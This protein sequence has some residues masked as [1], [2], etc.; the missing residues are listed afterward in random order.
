VISVFRRCVNEIFVLLGCYAAYIGSYIDVSSWAAWPL[1]NGIDRMSRNVG[2]YQSMLWKTLEERRSD[3]CSKL[4]SL[5]LWQFSTVRRDGGRASQACCRQLHLSLRLSVN[6]ERPWTSKIT[7]RNRTGNTAVVTWRPRERSTSKL[8]LEVKT[9]C[10]CGS[11]E[12]FDKQSYRDFFKDSTRTPIQGDMTEAR[13]QNRH[14]GWLEWEIT[15]VPCR[16]ELHL[17]GHW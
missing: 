11:R 9:T 3:V 6:Y 4:R 1:E 15:V 10:G 5:E 2:N 13:S 17:S 7:Y 12:R 16:V 8:Q 14:C